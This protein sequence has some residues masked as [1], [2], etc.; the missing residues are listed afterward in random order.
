MASKL[1]IHIPPEANPDNVTQLMVALARD[2]YSFESVSDLIDFA[3]RQ[4]LGTRTELQAIAVQM[5]LIKKIGERYEISEEGKAF[6][7]LKDSV[8]GD[9]LHFL[10]YSGWQPGE[11]LHFLPSWAYRRYCDHY[12]QLNIVELT[13]NFLDQQVTEIINDAENAFTEMGIA[14]FD[15]ISFSRKSLLGGR[16][17]LEALR[18]SV[19]EDGKFQRRDFC[20]P[21]LLLLAIGYVMRDELEAVD[22]DILLSHARRE[23]IC[24]VCLLDPSAFDQTL[25]WMIPLFPKVIL[26]SED[27]GYYGRYIRLHRRPTLEDI[28][29]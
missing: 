1:A 19:L 26:S 12:W 23:E 27:A 5:G 14:E 11:P 22:V 21:E 8:R 7:C 24:R 13:S 4:G 6:T 20:P 2:E 16:K 28:I 29:R 9:V 3:D 17:W 18:P 15:G 10:M 25:D